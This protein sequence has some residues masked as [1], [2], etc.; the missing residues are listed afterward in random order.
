MIPFR[1]VNFRLTLWYAFILTTI[2]SLFAFLMHTELART[3]YRDVDHN[4]RNEALTL[5]DS[6]ENYLQQNQRRISYSGKMESHLG[7]SLLSGTAKEFEQTVRSWEKGTQRV[8]R[9]V[10]M[11]RFISTGH[12]V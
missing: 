3:L 4:L 9:S 5:Q 12:K 10:L 2:L 8:S 6:L 7:T 11:V 1:S